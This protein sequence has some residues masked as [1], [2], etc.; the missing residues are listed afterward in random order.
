M[1]EIIESFGHTRNQYLASFCGENI[2][3]SF[4]VH[5]KVS[6]QIR[7]IISIV[8]LLVFAYGAGLGWFSPALPLL[9]SP[10]TPLASGPLTTEQLS[11]AGS[12]ISLGSLAGC[13]LA[14]YGAVKVG[15]KQ[16]SLIL[17]IPQLVPFFHPIFESKHSYL[18]QIPIRRYRGC[19]WY[20][21]HTLNA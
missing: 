20:S 9:L 10:E 18:I 7:V 6:W 4:P 21:V 14:G 3:L 16:T 2:L 8:N 17:V 12:V 11:F 13:L 5:W 1:I 15:T 19:F